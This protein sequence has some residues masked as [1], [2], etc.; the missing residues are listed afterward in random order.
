MVH[1]YRENSYFQHLLWKFWPNWDETWYEWPLGQGLPMLYKLGDK[2]MW[3]QGP[4]ASCWRFSLSMLVRMMLSSFL[5]NSAAVISTLRGLLTIKLL[6]KYIYEN[7]NITWFAQG[8]ITS[9]GITT[10]YASQKLQWSV[11]VWYMIKKYFYT[12]MNYL[13]LQYRLD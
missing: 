1:V 4:S 5:I 12:D 9:F 7:E 13:I 3:A 6:R 11:R 8:I 10:L 2:F